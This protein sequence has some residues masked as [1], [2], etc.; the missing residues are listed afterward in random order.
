MSANFQYTLL[1]HR[2]WSKPHARTKCIP[3]TTLHP[4]LKLYPSETKQKQKTKQKKAVK[5]SL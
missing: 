5:F 2:E 4:H 1:I 3:H